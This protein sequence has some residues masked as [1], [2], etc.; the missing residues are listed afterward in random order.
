[1]DTNGLTPVRAGAAEPPPTAVTTAAQ[2]TFVVAGLSVFCA[3]VVGAGFGL[4]LNIISDAFD[5]L[6]PVWAVLWGSIAAIIV[7]SAGAAA[8]ALGLMRRRRWAWWALLGLAPV[9]AVAGLVL[10]SLVFP[11]AWTVSGIAVLVLLLQPSAKSWFTPT[12]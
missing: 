8:A 12:A 2:V 10:W 1:M 6:D 5:D 9:S 11:L 4:V 7:G 3:V